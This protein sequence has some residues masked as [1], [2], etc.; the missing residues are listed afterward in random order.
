MPS[1]VQGL[2]DAAD[3]TLSG[4]VA[5][6]T[7]VPATSSGVYVVA[8]TSDPA[9]VSGAIRGCPVS[10]EAIEHWLEVRPELRL[11]GRRPNADELAE[12]LSAL[13]LADEV[14]LYIGKA[15][16]LT[17]RVMQYYV[18][19][20][21]ARRPH[22]GGHF[23]KTLTV[24]N[25]LH[26]HYGASD[27]PLESEAR[28]LESFCERVSSTSRRL[29][30]DPE[31]PFPFANLEW[32]AG[33]RKRHGITGGKEPR[34]DRQDPGEAERFRSDNERSRATPTDLSYRTQPVTE[35]DLSAGQI[36]IPV[37]G[38]TKALLPGSKGSLDVKLRGHVAQARW[39]PRLG[40]DRERSGVIRF[41]RGSPALRTVSSG[42]VLRVSVEADGTLVLE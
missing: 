2:F 39:D 12:R 16:S 22:A 41:G 10:R 36:R 23:L 32:P 15:S 29:L 6:G 20:L 19:P 13:W 37:S 4:S 7:A 24:L 38:P 33:T 3:L 8:L 42:E 5:W 40:P 35:K 28:M 34:L 25:D 14:V 26:V 21:G 27:G 9:D 11:D 30:H 18:T 31:R 1:T 17:S